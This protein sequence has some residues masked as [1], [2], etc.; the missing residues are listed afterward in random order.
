M[1]KKFNIPDLPFKDTDEEIK[2]REEMLEKLKPNLISPA[3]DEESIK[4]SIT[5]KVDFS[6]GNGKK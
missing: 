5:F 3:I 4:L 2:K 1:A 6:E